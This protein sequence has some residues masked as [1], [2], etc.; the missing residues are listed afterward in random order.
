MLEGVMSSTAT[1]AQ[2]PSESFLLTDAAKPRRALIAAI[3]TN[4]ALR[5]R[6]G[7]TAIFGTAPSLGQLRQPSHHEHL[8]ARPRAVACVL[9]KTTLSGKEFSLRRFYHVHSLTSQYTQ[10][11]TL[12][13]SSY[14][15]V[16]Q[17]TPFGSLLAFNG[18]LVLQALF[19]TWSLAQCAWQQSPVFVPSFH[20][21][22][23][24]FEY[25][26]LLF[27]F[28]PLQQESA[29]GWS[30][31]RSNSASISRQRAFARTV[32]IIHRTPPI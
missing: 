8:L 1:Q 6:N 26:E 23:S 24:F 21:P 31:T 2:P 12:Q 25:D 30:P 16:S 32:N 4:E 5:S 7:F 14:P 20:Q 29:T 19:A 10:K 18:L 13:P 11:N 28:T 15:S 27:A 9:F 17:V 3:Q 22:D